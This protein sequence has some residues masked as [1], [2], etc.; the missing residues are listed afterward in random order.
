MATVLLGCIC[1]AVCC[2][3]RFRQEKKMFGMTQVNAK[4]LISAVCVRY[5]TGAGA[6]AYT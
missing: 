6:G 2:I 4:I 5:C 1:L 3:L